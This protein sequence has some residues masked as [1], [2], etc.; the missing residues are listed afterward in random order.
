MVEQFEEQEKAR[1]V[2]RESYV[3]RIEIFKQAIERLARMNHKVKKTLDDVSTGVGK[4]SF[5]CN[6]LSE[7]ITCTLNSIDDDTI[8][9]PWRNSSALSAKSVKA[10][11]KISYDQLFTDNK[12]N[13][14]NH[15]PDERPRN[16][17]LRAVL[18]KMPRMFSD[19]Y[20]EQPNE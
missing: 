1:L 8:N 12:E 17:N 2:T 7:T 3:K 18:D 20:I 19:E 6:A 15:R 5:L 14:T 10:R 16:R 11:S 4:P 13:E 9:P